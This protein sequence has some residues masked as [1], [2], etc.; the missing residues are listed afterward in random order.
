MPEL[1]HVFVSYVREDAQ[2][3]DGLCKVLEAAQI[4]YWRDLTKLAPGDA[5]KAKIREAIRSNS[6]V[7]LACFSD[8]SRARA[9]SHMNEEL[10]LAVEEFRK[11]PPG[12]T[13]L[14]PVRFDAGPVPEWDL[15]A[16]RML[17]DLNYVDL[18][19]DGLVVQAASLVTT[20]SR[21]LGES[22]PDALT[23][24]AAIAQVADEER[25]ALLR[26]LT[27]EMLPDPARRI[28]LDETVRQE[29]RRILD[30]MRDEARFPTESLQGSGLERTASVVSQAT[31]MWRLI[32]PFVWSLEVAVRWASQGQLQPWAKGLRALAVEAT[33]TRGGITALLDLRHLPGMVSAMTIGLAAVG[34]GRWDN[35][36]ALLVDSTVDDRDRGLP[37]SLID[38]SDPWSPFARAGDWTAQTLA[39]TVLHDEDPTTALAHFTERKVG[40]YHTPVAEWMHH[41]LRPCFAELHLDNYTYDQEFD[42][43]EVMLGLISQDLASQSAASDPQ[44]SWRHRSS[45]FGRSTWRVNHRYGDPIAAAQRELGSQQAQ[46]APLRA[47]L[48]GGDPARAERAIAAYREWF[49]QISNSRW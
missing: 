30:A 26:R 44:T 38:V 39:R 9:K 35:L 17:S 42:L 18:F 40:K 11:L 13:W 25:P 36:K 16:G 31:D 28:E 48:F 46:W 14:I 22:A 24:Q 12:R 15:G 32:Q 3:V 34:S 21:L 41:I 47:G 27:K 7:F 33:R 23:I 6:L 20:I 29:T 8:H 2:L 37:V 19:G 45:W 4:P 49:T 1:Q 43:A 10:T 5:W